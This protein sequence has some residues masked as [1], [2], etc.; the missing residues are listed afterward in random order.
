MKGQM[1]IRTVQREFEK[2]TDKD[3]NAND[4]Q[5]LFKYSSSK[6]SMGELVALLDH[7]KVKA[8]N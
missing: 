8:A 6:K 7:H 2:Q 1:K 5:K 3:V 4:K